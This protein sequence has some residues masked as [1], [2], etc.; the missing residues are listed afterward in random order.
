[1]LASFECGFRLIFSGVDPKLFILD[2]PDSDLNF[3]SSGS[4]SGSGSRKKLR[5][6]AD[7]D[8]TCNNYESIIQNITKHPLYSFEKKNQN[9]YLQFSIQYYCP[10]ECTILFIFSF[11]FCWIRIRNFQLG[12]GSMRIQIHITG[13]TANVA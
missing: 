4:R 8:P 10:I 6:Q 13:Y 2:P 9:N 1:M 11:T 12:S 5:I 3:L 7:P